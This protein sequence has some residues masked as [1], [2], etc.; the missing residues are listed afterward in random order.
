MKGSRAGFHLKK[1]TQENEVKA[2]ENEDDNENVNED[3][4]IGSAPGDFNRN[5]IEERKMGSIIL[6]YF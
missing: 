2:E 5:R 4:L 1:V 6:M 3:E